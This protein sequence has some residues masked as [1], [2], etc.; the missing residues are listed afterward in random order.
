MLK[1]YSLHAPYQLQS[2]LDAFGRRRGNYACG[3]P[4]PGNEPDRAAGVRRGDN[5]LGLPLMREIADT[6]R[7]VL[8][9]WT[10]W[11]VQVIARIVGQLRLGLPND[12]IH[13]GDLINRVRADGGLSGK[14]HRIG[15][16]VNGIGHIT[17]FGTRGPRIVA[18]EKL[19]RTPFTPC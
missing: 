1:R 16:I 18:H 2:S 5:G 8:I 10:N 9:D 7:E 3:R 14:H 12:T 4:V 15:S 11:Q 17:S 13:T 6:L 19:M